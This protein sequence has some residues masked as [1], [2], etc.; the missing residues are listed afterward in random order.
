MN[1]KGLAKHYDSLTPWERLPLILAAS[2]RGGR[3]T[4]LKLMEKRPE[5]LG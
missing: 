3:T 4:W 1:T 5:W 2:S